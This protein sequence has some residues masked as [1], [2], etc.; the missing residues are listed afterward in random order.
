[1]NINPVKINTIKDFCNPKAWAKQPIKGG[2]IKNPTVAQ[3]EIID[4]AIP[5]EYFFEVPAKEKVIG[6]IGAVPKPTRQKP[7][8]ADQ[9]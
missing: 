4:I 3:V 6:N 1:M 5:A 2:P 9:K 7:N 8:K